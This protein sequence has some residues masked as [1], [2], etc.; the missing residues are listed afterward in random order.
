MQGAADMKRIVSPVCAALVAMH[1]AAFAGG[2]GWVSDFEAAK[3]QASELKKDLL[4]DF[5][6]SDWCGWCIKLDNEVFT[7]DPFKAG[8]KDHF[9]LVEVDS[10][11]DKSKL[12]EETQKQNEKLVEKYAIQGYP[13][14]LLCD[15]DGRPYAATGYQE[16]GPENYVEHLNELRGRKVAFNEA[17]KKA[18]E[19]EGVDKARILVDALKGLGLE[20]EQVAAFYGDIVEEIKQADPSDETGFAKNLEM[21]KRLDDFKQGL[22]KYGREK[23]H[24]GA[25]AHVEKAIEDGGFDKETTQQIMVTRAVI[26]MEMK[27]A[28]E[29]LAAL[30]EAKEYDPES[31]MVRNI[32]M[33][34][35]RITKMK[36]EG[37]KPAGVENAE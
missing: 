24:A 4:V 9:V 27:K 7:K 23:D 10:P 36:E 22:M 18:G 3:K 26:L 8:V 19:A 25:L 2:V 34:K 13:T 14:I 35:E 15:A 20:D 21:K 29:A 12:S 31:E 30:D 1:A 33:I 37:G 5:T 17:V 11:R 16:G 32:D 6:G 28:D